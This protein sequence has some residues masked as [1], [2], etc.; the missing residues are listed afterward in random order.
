LEFF[1]FYEQRSI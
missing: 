1:D